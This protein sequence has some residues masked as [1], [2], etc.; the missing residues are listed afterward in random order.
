MKTEITNL[1]QLNKELPHGARK[2]IADRFGK[3]Q[4]YV[5]RVLNG[6]AFNEEIIAEAIRIRDRHKRRL[7][8]L[9]NSI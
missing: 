7:T 6:K 8:Q 9:N 3:S 2:D 4:Q 5:S 1:D